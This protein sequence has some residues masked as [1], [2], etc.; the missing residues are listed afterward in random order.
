MNLATSNKRLLKLADF[1]EKLPRKRFDY[2][3][4]VGSSWEGA[5][6][7]S[8]GTTACALGWAAT[9]P[10]FRR[11]GLRLEK[12]LDREVGYITNRKLD[13]LYPSV[14][15]VATFGI[16]EEEEQ[17]LFEGKAT[18]EGFPDPPSQWDATPKQVA[19]HIRRFVKQRTAA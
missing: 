9:M 16:S 3:T 12:P 15:A 13:A 19:A 1:L 14:A 6:D 4:W 11:L 7:L 17:Y 18:L 10:E 8:C 5:P 2:S